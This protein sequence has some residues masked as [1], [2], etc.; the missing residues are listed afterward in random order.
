MVAST[1]QLPSSFKVGG[2]TIKPVVDIDE[3]RA[4]LLLLRRFHELRVAVE[5]D[6]ATIDAFETFVR[7][8][9]NRFY[10]WVNAGRTSEAPALDVA[11][12]WHAFM[13]VCRVRVEAR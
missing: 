1:L 8:S 9:A 5:A 2:N 3:C 10:E 12:V 11:M 4:H 13:L 6:S 7:G